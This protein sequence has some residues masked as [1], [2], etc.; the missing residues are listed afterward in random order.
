MKSFDPMKTIALLFA[1]SMLLH[2]C[3]DIADEVP[4]CIIEVIEQE[5]VGGC[6]DGMDEYLFEGQIVYIFTQSEPVCTDFGS[7]VYNEQCFELCFIGGI[8]GITHCNDV[9][10][11]QNAEF[12]RTVWSK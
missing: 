10:F 7:Q 11:F 3:S 4:D 1:A 12:Q 6:A 2:G 5:K 9:H 8:A